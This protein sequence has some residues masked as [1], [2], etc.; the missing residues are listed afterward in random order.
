MGFA[1]KVFEGEERWNFCFL[2]RVSRNQTFFSTK[3]GLAVGHIESR[4]RFVSA[5]H[6][7]CTPARLLFVI[8]AI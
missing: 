5:F 7:L 1:R 2:S 3:I 8:G 4:E 6:V